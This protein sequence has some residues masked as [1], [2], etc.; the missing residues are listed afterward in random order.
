M[1][2]LSSRISFRNHTKKKV[3]PSRS[4]CPTGKIHKIINSANPGGKNHA[5]SSWIVMPAYFLMLYQL[6]GGFPNLFMISIIYIYIYYINIYI[7][8]YYK[9]IYIYYIPN[10]SPLHPYSAWWC[11]NHLEKQWSSSMGRMTSHILR[12]NKRCLNNQPAKC[13]PVMFIGT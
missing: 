5:I 4:G 1:I 8:L 6:V 10:I 3:F 9:Y 12:K 13:L 7:Y 2:Q 11:N